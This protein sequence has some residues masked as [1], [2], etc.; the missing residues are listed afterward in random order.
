MSYETSYL[1]ITK[2]NL[3]KLLKDANELGARDCYF[4][5]EYSFNKFYSEDVAPKVDVLAKVR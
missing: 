1:R 4:T 3:I 2:G 5:N